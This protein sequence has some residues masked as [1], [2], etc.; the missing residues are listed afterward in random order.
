MENPFSAFIISTSIDGL[1]S[2]DVSSIAS[3][4]LKRFIGKKIINSYP[5]RKLIE[6][7]LITINL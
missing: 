2:K 5:A 3:R 4:L 1:C 6:V 7:N